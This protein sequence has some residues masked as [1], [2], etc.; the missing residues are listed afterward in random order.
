MKAIKPTWR[1]LDTGPRSAA[2]N[3]AADKV[4]LTA[5]SKDQVANTLRFL[6]F[7]PPSALVGY[8][9]A[10]EL[11]VNE[12][13]CRQQGIEINR[14]ITGGGSIYL[15]EG[16]LGWEIFVHRETP[17]I[18]QNLEDMYR[19]ICEGAVAGLARLG[20]K[21]QFRPKNDIEV[22]GRKISGSGGAEF[23]NAILYH[24]TLLTDFDVDTMIKCLKLPIHKLDDKPVQSF[25]K[26]VI[27]LREILG[28]LP[29]LTVIKRSL[30]EGFMESFQI[31]L[32]PGDL[33]R[34]EI[35]SLEKELPYF[36]SQEWIRGM[37]PK[38]QNSTLQVAD[39]KT[40][41]GLIRVSVLTDPSRHRIKSAFITGDFFAY[42]ERSILDL[43][44]A[45]KDSSSHPADLFKTVTQFFAGREIKIPGIEPD[46]FYQAIS[47]GV[48][49]A[50][51]SK[52]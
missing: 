20:V 1:L 33:N 31:R 7:S 22:N 47:L 11:E 29:P 21:A 27:C 23:E 10:V 16:Q 15:D 44:A 49:Q 8:H 48:T 12:A 3:M 46:D 37:R 6:E 42:P 18:P 36:R 43:E 14:R 34:D 45:L 30:M 52:E 25:K 39:H 26:R 13:Y 32:D 51:R 19:R 17:G 38:F 50:S 9:Q 4:I 2:Y 28:D 41:G 24:G 40:K 35:M 5:R